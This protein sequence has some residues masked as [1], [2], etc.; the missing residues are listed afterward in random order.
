MSAAVSQRA[1][2]V[3]SDLPFHA[4]VG[5]LAGGYLL[6]I[7]GMVLAG[8]GFV[9][10]D[11]VVT[12][13]ATPEMRPALKL[14]FL[15]CSLSSLLS[16]LVAVPAAY[17]L[18]RGRFRG[19]LVVDVVLDIP[20]I[21]PPL[22]VGMSLLILFNHLPLGG[23]S[24]DAWLVA[25]LGEGARVTFSPAAIVL[26]QFSV[27]CALAIR[28]VRSTLD[29]IPVRQEGVAMTL[30]CSRGQA[31]WRV[32]LP[33][34]WR[35]LVGAWAL[36]WARALGEFGPILVFAGVTR[37]RTEVLSTSVFL[38]M[39]LGNLRGA[40]AISLLLIVIAL[41]VLVVVRRFAQHEG[42]VV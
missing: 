24:I 20:V 11:D 28:V 23:R 35:G 2:R 9:G 40:V 31:F 29:E 4:G 8:L 5:L 7:V 22:V 13:M 34:A 3:S 16:I 38:E 37:G 32:L 15:T 21:L 10:W 17:L 12:V 14:T 25:W 18:S 36:A 30:G 1:Y 42:R 27:C 39:N 6:L 41:A 19:K 26:A 33:Q